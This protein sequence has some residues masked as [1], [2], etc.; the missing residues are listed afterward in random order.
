MLKLRIDQ[1][2]K[3]LR[4]EGPVPSVEHLNQVFSAHAYLERFHL[5]Y[6]YF[7][8][9]EVLMTSSFGTNS[10]LLLWMV[11]QLK[12]TQTVHFINTGYHFPETLAYKRFWEKHYQLQVQD[13]YP[14][15]VAHETT[16]ANSWWKH[17]PD[18]CCAVNKIAPLEAI[19]GNYKV[20]ISG[21]RKEQT[22]YREGLQVFEQ[23][24]AILKFHPLI[25]LSEEQF[26][27]E[28]KRWALPAH[29]LEA[30]GYG[31]IGCTHCT[32]KGTGRSG[33]WQGQEKTE[34]GLH[35]GYFDKKVV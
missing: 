31:S 28:T 10:A 1:P 26:L 14:Q 4:F 22:S 11:H 15:Q 32:K 35:P 8:E 30:Q 19:K 7:S 6:A 34:C 25:D 20:W 2:P 9:Q 21:L 16:R 5:L 3:K 13:L 33:R 27:A 29:P 23:Q 12:P 17:R 24:G 18:D